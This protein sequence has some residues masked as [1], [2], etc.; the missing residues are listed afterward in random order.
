MG[1]ELV[2]GVFV[3]LEVKLHVCGGERKDEGLEEVPHVG[4]G[5]LVDKTTK[6][7]VVEE[8]EDDESSGVRSGIR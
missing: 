7:V 3:M 5:K 1:E 6:S 4:R 8:V 2:D